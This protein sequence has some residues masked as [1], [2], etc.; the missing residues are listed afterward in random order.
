MWDVATCKQLREFD[1]PGP[2]D[3]FGVAVSLDG[4]SVAWGAGPIVR[5]SDL[6]SGAEIGLF[7]GHTRTVWGVAFSPD[8]ARLLSGADDGTMRLWDVNSRK[9][10]E[11]FSLGVGLTSVAFTPDGQH[12]LVTLGGSVTHQAPLQLWDLKARRDLHRLDA[13]RGTGWCVAV[14]S[15]DGRRVLAGSNDKMMR[16]WDLQTGKELQCF[17]GHGHMVR[18]VAF[19]PGGRR[20]LSVSYDGTAKVWDVAS[21]RAL[22]TFTRHRLW[23]KG[24]AIAPDGLHAFTVAGDGLVLRWRLPPDPVRKR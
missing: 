7:K 21:T 24:V 10:L 17:A 4:R 22:Y 18:N 23:V 11:V 5:L 3:V 2:K 8:G 1:C 9:Q 13:S 12:A 14:L 19:L 16:L 15:P 20:A 6:E